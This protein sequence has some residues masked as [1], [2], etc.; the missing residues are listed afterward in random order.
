MTVLEIKL[1]LPD[2]VAKEV[3]AAGLLT[4]EAIARLV[5]AERRARG[6]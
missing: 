5:R 1:S 6:C 4:P 2:S 3:Q